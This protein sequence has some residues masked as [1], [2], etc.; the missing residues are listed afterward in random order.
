MPMVLVWEDGLQSQPERRRA[1]HTK[2]RNGCLTCKARKLRCDERKP[3]CQRCT[4]TGR[5]CDG[6]RSHPTRSIPA[7]PEQSSDG[8]VSGASAYARASETPPSRAP[9]LAL[10]RH[11]LQELRSYRF[12]IEVTGAACSS[13]FDAEFW[14][15]ELPQACHA[16]PAIWHAAVSLGAIHE[17]S[18]VLA[19]RGRPRQPGKQKDQ[20][21]VFGLEQ[22]NRSIHHLLQPSAGSP[23]AATWSALTCSVLFTY[24][25]S[26]QGLNH[27]AFIHL[28]AARA[29]LQELASKKSTKKS[30]GPAALRASLRPDG[31]V[32]VRRLE[33]LVN[34]L[35]IQSAAFQNGGLMECYELV[36]DSD[37]F[38]AWRSYNAPAATT[39]S[40]NR[41]AAIAHAARAAESLLNGLV[42]SSQKRADDVAA[43]ASGTDLSKLKDLIEEQEPISRTYRELGI[44]IRAFTTNNLSDGTTSAPKAQKPEK[45]EQ[46]TAILTL[47]LFQATVRLLMYRDP[48]TPDTTSA[49][50][51]PTPDTPGGRD[52]AAEF[53][54]IVD[55]SEDILKSHVSPYGSSSV[56]PKPSPSQ[57]LFLVAHSGFP[58]ETRRRAIEVMRKYPRQEGLWDSLYMAELAELLLAREATEDPTSP[59]SRIHDMRIRFDGERRGTVTLRTWGEWSR[60]QEGKE[61][62]L[63]W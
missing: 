32:P 61:E 30:R 22:F 57:P 25:C 52:L 27:Q 42:V 50:E 54:M 11:S 6:Y 10:P 45:P 5:K 53:A 33:A 20:L 2:S 21:K 18:S 24:L 40:A 51:T 36:T 7:E 14:T 43:V 59:M 15:Q 31:P 62:R 26:L 37:P 3:A 63:Q 4:S 8:G 17:A 56:A 35:E 1:A 28:N 46:R 9:A 34:T 16:S 41:P 47:R 58:L 49:S 38:N 12:F 60:G 39:I 23:K 29:L 19:A 13:L 44:A 48:E 55:L